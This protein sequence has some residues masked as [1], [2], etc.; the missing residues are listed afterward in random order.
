M[1][2]GMGKAEPVAVIFAGG[3]GKRL[4]P[5]STKQ[6]PKQLDTAFSKKTLVG[7]AFERALTLYPRE[8][9]VIVTTEVLVNKIKKM[10]SLP[11]RNWI[12]QPYNVDTAAAIGL[13]ALHLETLFPEST[14]IIFYSDHKIA[15]L[16]GFK[17]TVRELER[18]APLHDELITVGT[19][20]TEPNT[21]FGYIKLGH[22]KKGR[23]YSVDSFVEK[24]DL[25]LAKKYVQSGNYVWNT[26]L[27]AWHS[28]TLLE[29]IKK[30]APQYYEQLLKLR[31]LIG[32]REYK[33]AV[34][35]WFKSVD[36][37]SF[38]KLVSERLASMLVYVGGYRWDD[39][40]NWETVYRLAPKDKNDNVILEREKGQQ[41]DFLDTTDSMVL[42]KTKRVALV[43]I[44][45]VFVV[46]TDSS[47]LI[48]HKD[49]IARV[50]ELVS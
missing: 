5:I 45:D 19:K 38:E 44:K 8:R 47:L 27:Y 15:N 39:V 7:E 41:V 24:P 36:H 1:N 16:V 30:A 12:V 14:A 43:G 40:G 22:H 18:L 32:S 2:R 48:C 31:V 29:A 42:S 33:P 9:I 20:P 21:Q 26:G 25:N 23:L 49:Q 28:L 6:L 50:K 10:V 4:W 35:K 17:H 11:A 34:E 13:T 3:E 46:E 37:L